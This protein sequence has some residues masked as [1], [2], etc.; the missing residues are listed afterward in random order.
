MA[1]NL[2]TENPNRERFYESAPKNAFFLDTEP[3]ALNCY[4]RNRGDLDAEESVRAAEIAGQGNMNLVV[5]VRTDRRTLILKQSR[6]WVEKYPQIDAPFDR[7]LVEAAFYRAVKSTPAAAFMPEFYWVDAESRII[8]MQD[9]GAVSDFS[10]LYSG[11]SINPDELDQLCRFLSLLHNV[12]ADIA[13]QEMKSLNHF[14]IFAFPFQIENGVDLD[15]ITPGL[16][17]ISLSLKRNSALIKRIG[18]LGDHY[19]A[20]GDFLLHGDYFPGSWVRGAAITKVI[21]PE[22]CFCGPREFDLG[23]MLAH[24]VISRDCS[25]EESLSHHYDSWPTLSRALIRNFAGV[26]ILRRILGVAQLPL[27]ERLT[28]KREL[29]EEAISLVSA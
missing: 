5:R 13:N 29:V 6:P 18:E 28:R 20:N 16:S 26:E 7:S 2:M 14:H 23:I 8:C 19:L 27:E 9:L 11:A 17:E 4:L 1:Q 21:D 12:H 22:F 3:E 25:A 24:L 10:D 15:K